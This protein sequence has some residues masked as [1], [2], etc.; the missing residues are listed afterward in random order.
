MARLGRIANSARRMGARA[1]VGLACGAT[2]VMFEFACVRAAYAQANMTLLG[3][4]EIGAIATDTQ[5]SIAKNGGLSSGTVNWTVTVTKQSVS[6]QFIQIEGF[7]FVHNVGTGPASLGNIV[8]NLQRPCGSNWV[9]AAADIADATNGAVATFANI[10]AKATTENPALNSPSSSCVGPGNYV[11]TSL[12]GQ[13]HNEGT[14]FTTPGSGTVDFTNAVNN[15]VFSLMPQFTIKANGQLVLF[16]SATFD[17]TVL[18]LTPGSTIR[19]ETIVSVSDVA[20]GAPLSAMGID[21][22]D[23]DGAA[24]GVVTQDPGWSQSLSFRK[25]IAPT[26]SQCNQTINLTDAQNSSNPVLTGTATLKTFTSFNASGTMPIDGGSMS[27]GQQLNEPVQAQ[28]DGGS[29]GGAITNCAQITGADVTSQ[30]V[31]GNFSKTF[32]VCSGVSD[33]GCDQ[34]SVPKSA[35][36]AGSP[37]PTAT[38]T[39]TPIPTDTPVATPTPAPT[40]VSPSPTPTPG[41]TVTPTPGGTATPTPGPTATPIP[42][43]TPAPTASPTPVATP[44]PSATPTPTVPPF[45]KGEFCTYNEAHWAHACGDDDDNQ[46]ASYEH[47]GDGHP[48]EGECGHGKS[49]GIL[50][51]FF[52]SVYGAAGGVQVG[53]ECGS[54]Q[55]SMLFTSAAAVDRYLPAGGRAGVLNA[56]LVNPTSSHS[57]NFGGEVLALE[58]NVDFSAAGIT[59]GSGGPFGDLHL[60]GTGSSLD[61]M[62]IAEILGAANKALGNG[63]MP[64]SLNMN[65]FRN[66]LHQLNQS[67]DKCDPHG[68]AQ[69][70]LTG[71][72]CR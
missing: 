50:D 61:G 33:S 14:F 20:P 4:N 62:T 41:A 45:T 15:S 23:D 19:P 5:W 38:P 44:S 63:G 67:F 68:F 39:P 3:E 28:V 54:D 46:Y 24:S 27:V 70:H 16:Y 69:R 26:A 42:T 12:P 13:V 21:V 59:E 10:V 2:A 60:C 34:E 22:D 40:P 37:T 65:S 7:M 1:I 30:L 17:N 8:I 11:I 72:A 55:F 31:S 71:G 52:G 48:M 58:L 36:P 9:S 49:R 47:H 6:D 64:A 18:G 56:C 66:L 25:L 35:G 32:T 43:P 57:G 29:S 53:L 51:Q